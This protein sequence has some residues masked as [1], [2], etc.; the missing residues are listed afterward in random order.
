MS[1]KTIVIYFSLTGNTE[2]I[3]G[4]VCRGVKSVSGQC[5]LI[6]LE[7]A[8]GDTASGY[9]LIGIGTPVWHATPPNVKQ[10]VENLA[11]I[12]GKHAFVFCT[13]GT[14]A[15]PFSPEMHGILSAKGA[16][17]LGLGEWYGSVT[18][19]LLPKPYLTD[20]HPDAVDLKEAEAFGKQMFELSRRVASGETGLIPPPPPE[21]PPR[22][23]KVPGRPLPTLNRE[24]CLY[25]KC[26]LCMDHCPVH[27]ID[28]SQNPS[29]FAKPCRFCYFCEMICPAG[30]IDA[31]YESYS[32]AHLD[33]G[34]WKF[35]GPLEKAEAEGRFRRLIPAEKIDWNTP[36][37][38]TV[39]HHPR[40]KIP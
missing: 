5:G 14:I 17:V 29:I 20:G 11:G 39:P 23:D 30:A 33:Y 36:Y 27:G 28:L 1:M 22:H 13:H 18:Q 3:A 8:A 24:K 37:F 19:P 15:D 25:P 35:P 26:S 7:K 40:Y 21:P 34:K 31:D 2:K 38:K 4:A 12:N 9:D 6:T 32:Q 16:A 10:F